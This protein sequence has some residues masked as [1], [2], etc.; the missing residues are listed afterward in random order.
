MNDGTFIMPFFENRYLNEMLKK[1][2]DTPGYRE[3]APT[4]KVGTDECLV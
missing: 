4:V 1:L 2:R 3:I